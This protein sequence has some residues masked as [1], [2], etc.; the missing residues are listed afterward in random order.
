LDITGILSAA[1]SLVSLELRN[2]PCIASEIGETQSSLELLILDLG[3]S[4]TLSMN[5]LRCMPHLNRLVLSNVTPSFAV[6]DDEFRIVLQHLASLEIMAEQSAQSVMGALCLPRLIDLNISSTA[7]LESV[8]L[9]TARDFLSL[10]ERSSCNLRRLS[11][12]Y[13][14]L[15]LSDVIACLRSIPTLEVMK[16][17]TP[18]LPEPLS[19]TVLAALYVDSSNNRIAL[20]N[21]RDLQLSMP[22]NARTGWVLREMLLGRSGEFLSPESG[23]V[24][25]RLELNISHS[26]VDTVLEW[27]TKVLLYHLQEGGVNVCITLGGSRVSV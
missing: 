4:H 15:S 11:L 10:I 25:E 8:Q 12:S 14:S 21:I 18:F 16:V 5:V 7:V 2:I 26:E 17:D 27:E 19:I 13:L 3:Y 1:P 22:I 23:A 9:F 20:P 24:L 6:G